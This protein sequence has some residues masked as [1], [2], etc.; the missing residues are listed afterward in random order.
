MYRTNALL[1]VKELR[2]QAIV[3]VSVENGFDEKTHGV[4]GLAQIVA[5]GCQKLIFIEQGLLRVL[6]GLTKLF[7]QA[8]AFFLK[9]RLLYKE[10][11]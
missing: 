10:R 2:R 5:G 8:R 3:P 6:F 1:Q 7:R 4:H 11:V 9:K